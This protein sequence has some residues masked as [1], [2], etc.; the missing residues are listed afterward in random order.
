MGDYKFLIVVDSTSKWIEAFKMTNTNASEVIKK[1]RY[2]FS[3]FGLPKMI[4]S[5]NGPPFFSN[6]FKL[7]L[8]GNKIAQCFS[9]PYHPSSNGAA[10][11]AVK[12]CKSVIKKAIKENV[13][14]E[15]A[16]HRYLLL[17]RNTEHAATGD[18]PARLLQGR[19]LRTRL[20]ALKPDRDWKMLK[21]QQDKAEKNEG[22]HRKLQVGDPVY[23][24]DFSGKRNWTP[25]MISQKLG[26]T[27]YKV[28]DSE[29]RVTHRHIDQLKRRSLAVDSSYSRETPG[30]TVTQQLFEALPNTEC[31]KDPDP[32]G[33][34]E[35][36][37]PAAAPAASPPAAAPVRTEPV[38]PYTQSGSEL[39]T[40]PQI[41]PV[42]RIKYPV[43]RYGFEID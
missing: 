15:V 16:L 37:A 24:K 28:S 3:Q 33:S 17:Y 36:S 38:S 9:A 26:S 19:N 6:T 13:D 29:G 1:L 22:S 40:Q 31:C 27:D 35:A 10:E 11:N 7:F 32:M 30:S 4:V 43:K 18:S 25:G 34:P 21:S 42:K 23:L 39:H 14:V 41:L 8:E 12:L 2:L 20:D 5:D